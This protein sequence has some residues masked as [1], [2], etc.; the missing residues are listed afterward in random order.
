MLSETANYLSR[1][2]DLHQQINQ[3]IAAAPAAGLDWRP[4]A[5]R[6]EHTANSLAVLAVHIA[7]AEHFWIGEVIGGLP[8]TR[9]RD[10]EFST[11]SISAE[12]LIHLLDHT[13][14][15]TTAIFSDLD[16][17]GMDQT[18]TVRGK[19][20][21][22]RWAIVHVIDHTALHLGHMQMTYQLLT[23]GIAH[24]APLWDQ[25]LPQGNG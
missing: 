9:D 24:P 8:P 19:L 17:E 20:V 25:R 23:H 10:A 21:A 2:Q 11:Q 4:F 16:N 13:L 22:V 18:R 3:L 14:T 5:E 6:E 15:E 7:G 1:I 12:E